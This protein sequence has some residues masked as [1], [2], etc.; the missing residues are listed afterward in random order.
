[1]LRGGGKAL[2]WAGAAVT[3]YDIG[4]WLVGGTEAAAARQGDTNQRVDAIN[5]AIR[6]RQNPMNAAPAGAYSGKD[7]TLGAFGGFRG[8]NQAPTAGGFKGG[9]TWVQRMNDALAKLP[10]A[11]Q[12]LG[13]LAGSG[14]QA[15]VPGVI[16]DM[17]QDNRSTTVNI[18][19]TITQAT[20]APMAAAQATGKAVAQAGMPAPARQASEPGSSGWGGP[21]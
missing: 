5:A 18:S 19:Q 13:T 17:R 16:N 21:R 2:G 10:S 15:A 11:M 3:A 12:A 14:P 9:D 20:D 1:L 8:P 7:Y 4:K 6:A